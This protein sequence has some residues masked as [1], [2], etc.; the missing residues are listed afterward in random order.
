MTNQA[1]FVVIIHEQIGELAAIRRE[2]VRADS[3]ADLGDVAMQALAELAGVNSVAELTV[4][5]DTFLD[6]R[7]WGMHTAYWIG[8]NTYW[9]SKVTK[10]D[11]ADMKTFCKYWKE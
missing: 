9:V 3:A 4:F 11:E 5:D 8:T 2:L 1:T 10:I 7:D 6:G